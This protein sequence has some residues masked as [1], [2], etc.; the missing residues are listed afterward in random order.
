MTTVPST[1][2]PID[3]DKPESA[4]SLP[5]LR[6]VSAEDVQEAISS[7]KTNTKD[8]SLPIYVNGVLPNPSPEN[9]LVIQT[10]ALTQLSIVVINEQLVQLQ[11]SEGFSVSVSAIDS[12]GQL[13][14]VNASGSIVVERGNYISVAGTGF[15]PNSD[16]VAWLFSQ[17]RRLGVIRTFADGSFEQSLKVDSDILPGEH[18]Q[19][20]NGFTESGEIRSINLAL[21]VV[22][23]AQLANAN[24]SFAPGSIAPAESED[25]NTIWL[26]GLIAASLLLTAGAGLFAR[27]KRLRDQ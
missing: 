8:L 1:K 6:P 23:K 13:A 14:R 24:T 10:S 3:S 20:V 26:L 15:Q 7:N 27:S 16:V 18:T 25:S 11:D 22:D 9:P 21:E 19:Q 12:Q 5:S 2:V 17:P 4:T